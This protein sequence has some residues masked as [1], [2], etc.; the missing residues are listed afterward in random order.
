[1]E[2]RSTAFTS[3]ATVGN[4]REKA[5]LV[6]ALHRA[7]EVLRHGLQAYPCSQP[8]STGR[9]ASRVAACFLHA[10][11]NVAPVLPARA[12]VTRINPLDFSR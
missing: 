12:D 1:M 10:L 8:S 9:Q 2:S 6:A 7:L 3:F 11:V 4:S 5:A